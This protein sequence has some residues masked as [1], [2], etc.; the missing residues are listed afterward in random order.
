MPKIPVF[1]TAGAA[2]VIGHPGG[3]CVFEPLIEPN[4][5]ARGCERESV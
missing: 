1:P 4:P 3:V 5:A 2:S